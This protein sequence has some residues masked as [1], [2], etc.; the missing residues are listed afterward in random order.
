MHTDRVEV[1]R[2]DDASGRAFGAIADAER[3][4]RDLF[5]DE[6]I[7]QRAAAPQVEPVGPRHVLIDRCTALRCRDRVQPVLVGDQRIRTQE[8]P[9]NPAQDGGVCAHAEREAQDREQREPGTSPQHAKPVSEIPPEVVYPA[10]H[11]GVGGLV[12]GDRHV[13]EAMLRSAPGFV[14]RHP[15]ADEFGSP[16]VEVKTGF[17]VEGLAGRR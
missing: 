1:V 12:A 17:L 14:W 9:L 10:K 16:F 4:P 13:A 3:G 7:D 11:V 2:R 5:G 8:N 15:A 6:R